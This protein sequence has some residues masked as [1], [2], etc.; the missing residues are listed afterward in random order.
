VGV[1]SIAR[2]HEKTGELY[3]PALAMPPI[4]HG[5]RRRANYAL[6]GREASPSC[7]AFAEHDGSGRRSLNIT[8]SGF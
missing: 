4:R 3:L 5:T 6:F 2:G 1:A 7:S 8:A